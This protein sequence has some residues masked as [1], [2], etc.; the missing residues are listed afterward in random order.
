MSLSIKS[1]VR[2]SN[3]VEMPLLGLGTYKSVEPSE[4]RASLE[5]ALEAGYRSVDTA[6]MYNNEAVIGEV[7]ARSGVP[8]EELFVATKVWNDEQ[9]RNR[10]LDAFDRSMERLGLEYLD[11][12][13]IHWPM[14]QFYAETWAA[15]QELYRAGRVR[16]IGVC[17]FLPGHLASLMEVAEVP[18]MVDQ[19]EFH[20]WLQQPGLQAYCRATGI[21]LE[22]WAPIMRGHVAEVPE[23]VRI[24]KEHGVT[25]YQVAI[26]WIMQKGIVA[27]PKSVHPDRV[28]ANADVFGFELSTQEMA[29]VG[30]LDRDE[31]VGRHPDS[32]GLT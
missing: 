9:G 17:N 31:R 1:T 22:A 6:S 7:L 24:A 4:V 3:G 29:T 23:I 13:L 5:A 18:P 10:T 20:P 21:V 11:L 28:R 32:W 15:M 27:I 14:A 26:R 19:V 16:A 30:S 8:R 25:P 12:Y 2:L